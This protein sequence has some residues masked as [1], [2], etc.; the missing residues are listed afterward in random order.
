MRTLTFQLGR[1]LEMPLATRD[2]IPSTI[3]RLADTQKDWKSGARDVQVRCRTNLSGD[4]ENLIVRIA[5]SQ[6]TLAIDYAYSE[7]RDDLR[8]L[9]KTKNDE[10]MTELAALGIAFVLVTALLPDDRITK[11]VPK[12]ERGDFYL[13]D[14]R[15]EMIEISGTIRRDLGK[16]FSEKKQQI[17]LNKGLRRAL[18]SVSRFS[19]ASSR[20]ER[21]K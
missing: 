11:V 4:H 15:D 16:L 18:V 10:Q 3:Y 8:K 2:L 19:D 20:L 13:N 6:E 12:G 5:W 21:V 14:S 9:A 17:L 1:L 7:I